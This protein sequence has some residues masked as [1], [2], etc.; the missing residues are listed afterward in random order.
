MTEPPTWPPSPNIP[1]PLS[2]HDEFLVACVR[3]STLK[4]PLSRLSLVKNLRDETGLDLRSCLATVNHFCNK[5]TI[6]MPSGSRWVWAGCLPPIIMLTM[7]AAINISWTIL[8][9]R[10]DAA[11]T[12]L[13][14]VT[15][16]TE[17]MQL[18]FVFLGVCL[19]A[20]CASVILAFWNIKKTRRQAAEAREKFAR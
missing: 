14:R 4:T 1:E 20:A 12:H 8:G 2:D 13:E 5:H 16:T 3:N 7:A 6:L 18:D 11:A 17:R 15:I 9:R 10:H 19:A